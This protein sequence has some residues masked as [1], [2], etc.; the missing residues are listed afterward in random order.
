MPINTYSMIK[1]FQTYINEGLFDRNQSEFVVK[2]TD[3]GIERIYIPKTKDELYDT[4]RTLIDE[5]GGTDHPNLN[6]I[7]ISYLH[8]PDCFDYLFSPV[9][10]GFN[11]CPDISSWNMNK[12]CSAIGMFAGNNV[13]KEFVVP[14]GITQLGEQFFRNTTLESVVIPEGVSCI[15]NHLFM[16]CS[17]LTSIVI[18][19][20]VTIIENGAFFECSSL[21][22]IALPNSITDIND[23]A[24]WSCSKL[25]HIN[26]PKGMKSIKREMFG[27]CTGLESIEIPDNIKEIS[28][29]AFSCSG[30]KSIVIPNGVTH[31]GLYA[32][33]ECFSLE[34]VE[35]PDSVR[36]IDDD[37]FGSCR[38]LKQLELPDKCRIS[39]RITPLETKLTRRHT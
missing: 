15:R 30:L 14:E 19:D 18:P 1:D 11:V 29:Q 38:K 9:K 35:I 25:K 24:F 27:F 39:G 7:D 13:I 20:S 21:T 31:I 32:F 28:D 26:I 37:A 5:Q 22:S 36:Q 17:N 16:E 4:I 6:N 8:E 3:K 10:G 23:Y 33:D 12:E 34:H 2:R